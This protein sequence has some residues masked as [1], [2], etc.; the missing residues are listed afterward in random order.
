ML[1]PRKTRLVIVAGIAL[2]AMFGLAL[3]LSQ[4]QFKPGEPVDLGKS[5]TAAG[6]YATFI[7]GDVIGAIFQAVYGLAII[8]SVLFIIYMLIDPQR[9][10]LLGKSLLRMLPLLVLAYLASQY[11]H[12]CTRSGA[13]TAAQPVGFGQVTPGAQ[14]PTPTFT[15]NLSPGLILAASLLLA[16]I[17]AGL[18]TVIIIRLRQANQRQTTPL[19]RLAE[20]AQAALDALNAGGNLKN[21]VL[22]CYY[23][24]NR[25]LLAEKGFKRDKSMTPREFEALLAGKGLPDDP[26]QQLT[27]LFEAVRYGA[28]EP[29]ASQESTARASLSAI[30]AA[31][32]S[33]A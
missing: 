31:C 25:I 20:Q 13:Q 26:I 22:R 3:G 16:L 11:V 30:I 19:L 18:A 12:A 1:T 4:V 32:R 17:A 28:T 14:A 5:T 33:M 8:A 7:D 21:A 27:R 23:E 9:R 15:P 29:G 6:S 24:M 2:L 10:K